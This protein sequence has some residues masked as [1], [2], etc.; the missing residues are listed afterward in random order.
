MLV[1]CPGSPGSTPY[2]AVRIPPSIYLLLSTHRFLFISVLFFTSSHF[3]QHTPPPPPSP[4]HGLPVCVTTRATLCISQDFQLVCITVAVHNKTVSRSPP[5][6]LILLF[7][8][9]PIVV[10]TRV[11]CCQA[12]AWLVGTEAGKAWRNIVWERVSHAYNLEVELYVP[13]Y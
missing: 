12:F 5:P 8:H 13:S 1:A 9:S 2:T 3:T 7:L 11:C 10:A 4:S 6:P